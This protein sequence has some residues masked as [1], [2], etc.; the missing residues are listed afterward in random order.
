MAKILVS[1]LFVAGIAMLPCVAQ[2]GGYGDR[3]IEIRSRYDYDPS[4]RY[5]GTVD[6]N[7]NVEARPKYDYDYDKRVRGSIDK[8]GSG[9]VRD[10]DWNR[11]SIRSR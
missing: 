5:V 4:N 7:G 10:N 1:A 6:R 2:A 11:W 3:E 8:Y 9:S